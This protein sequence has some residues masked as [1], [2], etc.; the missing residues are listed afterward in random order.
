ML[1]A[2]YADQFIG[3]Y[4]GRGDKGGLVF[5]IQRVADTA[6][7]YQ[8][9]EYFSLTG[10][11][12]R[13]YLFPRCFLCV[14]IDTRCTEVSDTADVYGAIFCDDQPGAGSLTII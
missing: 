6:G 11:Y 8:L 4:G 1:V 2:G 5:I 3:F 9:D 7:M 10:V 12:G 14:V 13:Y